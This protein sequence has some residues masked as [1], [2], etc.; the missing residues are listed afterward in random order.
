M[1]FSDPMSHLVHAPNHMRFVAVTSTHREHIPVTGES[2]TNIP[3]LNDTTWYRQTTSYSPGAASGGWTFHTHTHTQRHPFTQGHTRS[4]SA[5]ELSAG[6][7][8]L[9]QKQSQKQ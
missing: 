4:T 7:A 9:P 2:S 3:V 1:Q 5:Q 8:A 6:I